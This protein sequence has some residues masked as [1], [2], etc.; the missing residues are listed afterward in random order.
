MTPHKNRTL[1]LGSNQKPAVP[2]S[3]SLDL[4][5]TPNAEDTV[6]TDG[7]VTTRGRGMNQLMSKDTYDREQKQ[8][9]EQKQQVRATK[10]QQVNLEERS[11]LEKYAANNREVI[12]DGLRFQL[13]ED[14][15]KLIRISGKL[16]ALFDVDIDRNQLSKIDASTAS[17]ESPKK[18]Q[19]S[20]VDFFRTKNGNLVRANAVRDLNRY[21]HKH[22]FILGDLDSLDMYSRPATRKD[23]P[24]CEHFTKHGTLL[25]LQSGTGPARLRTDRYRI[26]TGR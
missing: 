15:S 20:D 22:T 2:S 25:P 13:R 14:G 21:S 18:A 4:D 24:Q 8:K 7:F 16:A 19:I 1:V 10:K 26:C 23:K 17:K 11:K 6:A 5:T 9:L 12:I 3:I